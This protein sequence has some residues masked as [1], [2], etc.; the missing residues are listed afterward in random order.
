MTSFRFRQFAI[1][2]L[3]LASVSSIS[4]STKTEGQERFGVDA[5]YFIGLKLLSQGNEKEARAKFNNCIKKGS[6]YCGKKSAEVL[7]SF[8]NIQEKNQAAENLIK[9]YPEKDS[10][11][12]AAKQF[13]SSN[14]I[15]KL[16]ECTQ[17]LNPATDKNELIKIRLTALNTRGDSSY[18]QEVYDW[19]TSCPVSKEHYQ[20]YRDTYTH[21]DFDA[22]YSFNQLN[23]EKMPLR[24]TPEQFAVNY[25]IELYKR[26]YTYTLE[27]APELIKYMQSG[28]LAPCEQLASDIGKSYLYG[29]M[30][31]A[32]NGAYFKK[33]GNEAE[34]SE[35]GKNLAF[36]YWFYAG[37]LY[38]KAGIYYKQTK[39]AFEKAMETANTSSQKDNALWYL[40]NN[41]LNF[42][43]DSIVENISLY[44]PQWSDPE[45]FEDLFEKLV[46]SLLAS[47]K[48]DAFYKIYTAVD[49]FASDETVA[50][51]A[52]IYGRLVEEGLAK[53]DDEA[54]KKAYTRALKS[55]SGVYYKIL[56]AYKLGLSGEELEK[57]LTA[58][59]RSNKESET[60]EKA[61]SAK[62]LL[63]GYAFFG[64]P[65][66]I[67][68]AWQE[69]YSQG[70]SEETYFY[71]AEFLDQV[72]KTDSSEAYFTQGT[73][74]AARGQSM[75]GRNLTRQEIRQVYPLP[76]FDIVENYCKKYDIKPSVIYALIRSESFFDAAVTSSAGA[77]GLTQLMEF[78][79]G[80][81]AKRLKIQ[82]YDLTDPEISI[83]FG[84]Y[85]LAE[86]VRRC[87][88]SLL[89]A[90]FS[91]NAGITRVRRWL[92]SSLIEFGKKSNMP[93]D[94]YL[95]TVP[96]AETREY[97]R[98]LV[99]AT[100]MYEW[101]EDENNF[102]T[103]VEEL[104]R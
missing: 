46:S 39:N 76:Y 91:Y 79:G 59:Y 70:L 31:F 7:C 77:I 93:S 99:S 97:G 52:Y 20:F 22:A 98:K 18:E 87:D 89:Q 11:L 12:L 44:A 14:E 75:A 72:G 83:N 26:N 48:W 80:D 23:E 43:V 24:Y 21:P 74:I 102:A 8:G 45:Y 17:N 32:N 16:I 13:E 6:Y 35:N 88:D 64:F 40:L 101:L 61:E 67:Y 29:S 60:S 3:F 66:L 54:V 57:V 9:L 42:S 86:L 100:V 94:L 10:L 34:L 50:R 104:L 63:E 36:Y 25:R 96:Y 15:N 4:C 68:P 58:P 41:S 85:Y 69:L 73:R 71:L 53:G 19:F 30:D 103:A 5:D 51:Y 55:G 27:V 90:F 28:A 95:E 1:L 49:G 82:D 47:G 62:K 38:E 37:R 56:G 81:I 2:I 84:T 78:T 92:K 33:L 65:K